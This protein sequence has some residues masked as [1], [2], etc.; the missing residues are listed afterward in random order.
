M[1]GKIHKEE[2][3]VY[4]IEFEDKPLL[5]YRGNIPGYLPTSPFLTGQKL[6]FRQPSV[7]KYRNYLETRREEYL[8]QIRKTLVRELEVVRTY[9]A[10]FFG[11]AIKLTFEEAQKVEIISGVKQIRQDELRFLLNDQVH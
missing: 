10:G 1:P 8:H 11:I 5:A 3:R 6:D 7:I 4:I 2:L 9:E